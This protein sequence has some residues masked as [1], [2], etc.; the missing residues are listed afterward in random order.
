MAYAAKM[1]SL[2]HSLGRG[3]WELLVI[4]L[5]LLSA[6]LLALFLGGFLIDWAKDIIERIKKK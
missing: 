4:G 2:L 6:Y 5:G 3:L 1:V